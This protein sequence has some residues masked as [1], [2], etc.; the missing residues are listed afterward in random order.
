MDQ[1]KNVEE[2]DL[3]QATVMHGIRIKTIKTSQGPSQ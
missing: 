3:D 1:E 2:M